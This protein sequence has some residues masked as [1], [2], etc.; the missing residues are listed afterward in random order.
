MHVVEYYSDSSKDE[1]KDCFA[2][3][4]VWPAQA[5]S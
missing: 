4:F 3:E 2:I 1:T 5:D